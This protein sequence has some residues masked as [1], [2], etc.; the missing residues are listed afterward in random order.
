MGERF[1]P[2]YDVRNGSGAGNDNSLSDIKTSDFSDTGSAFPEAMAAIRNA[3][4]QPIEDI[5]SLAKQGKPRIANMS[6]PEIKRLEDRI[7]AVNR[8]GQ[9]RLDAV[10]ARIEGK[11]ETIAEQNRNMESSLAAIRQDV[12]GT[13]STIKNTALAS[14]LA[15]AGI[16]FAGIALWGGGF[17]SGQADRPPVVSTPNT[18]T[19]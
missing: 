9:L 11:F 16:V 14:V 2:Y 8:E 5:Q 17:S 6:E 13:R 15:I 3:A 18:S 10:M 7:D 12:S 1:P 4:S 19:H